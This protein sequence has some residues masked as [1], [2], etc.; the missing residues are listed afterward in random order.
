MD[1]QI[2]LF[3]VLM[4]YDVCTFAWVAGAEI[5]FVCESWNMSCGARDCGSKVKGQGQSKG[6][7][8]GRIMG[9]K[10]RRGSGGRRRRAEVSQGKVAMEPP[11]LINLLVPPLLLLLLPQLS[12][13]LLL[14]LLFLPLLLLLLCLLLCL[15]LLLL[16]SLSLLCLLLLP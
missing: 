9:R 12:L 7:L 16:P 14:R 10:A 11:L 15:L 8:Y 2:A 4:V 6:G 13:L 3:D 5:E 1:Y